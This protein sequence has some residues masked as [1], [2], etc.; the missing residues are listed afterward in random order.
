MY[1]FSVF[2]YILG[3]AVATFIHQAAQPPKKM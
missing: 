2:I 1:P 3:R